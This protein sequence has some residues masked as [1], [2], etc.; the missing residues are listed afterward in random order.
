MSEEYLPCSLENKMSSYFLRT[1]IS[2]GNGKYIDTAHV[3]ETVGNQVVHMWNSC[4]HI[5]KT[6]SNML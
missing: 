2:L 3:S 1:C 4:F 6:C 5:V